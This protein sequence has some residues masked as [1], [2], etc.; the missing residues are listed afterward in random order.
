[1]TTQKRKPDINFAAGPAKLPVP[2]IEKARSELPFYDGLGISV[3]EMSH[4][5][6]DYAQLHKRTEDS[7]RRLLDVPE[8]YKVLFMSGG[9][10]GQFS[11]VP[12][13]LMNTDNPT[14]DYIVTGNWSAKA[15]KEAEK[16]GKVNLAFPKPKKF[17]N[18][19]SQDTWKLNPEASY[20]YYCANET[21]MGI[22]FPFVPD[23]GDVPL[24]CDMSS[25][26][27]TKKIDVSKFGVI[28]A[29]A[30]KNIGCAG[31]TLVIVREDLLGKASPLCPSVLDYKI[32]ADN[33]SSYNTP[34]V[35]NIYIMGL[36]FDWIEEQGGVEAMAL[37]S[38]AKSGLLYS[39][40]KQFSD[41]YF[42]TVDSSVRSRVNVTFRIGGPEGNEQLE[43]QFLSECQSRGLVS[44]KGYRLVGGVRVSLYNAMTVD[45]VRVLVKF[46][47]EFGERLR[48]M[49]P[50]E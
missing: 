38:Q 50:C 11:A 47:K 32:T 22:E 19:P 44:L 27:L 39:T 17:E 2:V 4:R 31:V 46:M 43:K 16:Y 41:I 25:N 10:T 33:N 34:P 8:N 45:E 29:G 6:T 1:M 5:S 37:N 9:G 26:I 7:V 24:V 3:M 18:I 12:L 42:G 40:M 21:A 48:Q 14:A 15:V 35:W 36:V 20:V 23:T 28:L 30:Q 49:M 13:N